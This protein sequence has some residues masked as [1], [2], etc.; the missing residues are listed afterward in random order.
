MPSAKRNGCSTPTSRQALTHILAAIVARQHETILLHGVTGSGKTEVYIRAI[1]EV[2]GY[3]PAGDRAG[4]GDQPHAA[5]QASG[6]G[7][8]STPWPCCTAT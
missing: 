4:A 3:R 6:S 8:G 5:D 1:Q 2:V 7:R